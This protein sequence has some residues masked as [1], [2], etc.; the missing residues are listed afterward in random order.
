MEVVVSN[1]TPAEIEFM[2]GQQLGRLATV[3]DA[4]EPYPFRGVG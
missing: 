1:F 2:H 4:G 3:E